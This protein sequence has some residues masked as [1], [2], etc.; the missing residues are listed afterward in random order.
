MRCAIDVVTVDGL[1]AIAALLPD[2]ARERREPTPDEI[3]RASPPGWTGDP[4]DAG[5]E[6]ARRPGTD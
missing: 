1:A 2:E 4:S 6:A 3:R 5:A